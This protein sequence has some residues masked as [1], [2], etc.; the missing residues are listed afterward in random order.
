MINKILPIHKEFEKEVKVGPINCVIKGEVNIY[1]AQEINLKF[2]GL[3]YVDF[4]IAVIGDYQ[5]QITPK[6]PMLPDV[7][8]KELKLV[9][10]YAQVVSRDDN[11]NMNEVKI[12]VTKIEE[13]TGYPKIDNAIKEA[14][15]VALTKAANDSLNKESAVLA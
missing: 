5:F 3:D 8:H 2:K 6:I 4:S 12:I 15:S 11:G 10:G 7:F 9:E 1:E 13:G 14:I